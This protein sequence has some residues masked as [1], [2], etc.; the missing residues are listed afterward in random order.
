V[1]DPAESEPIVCAIPTLTS[2]DARVSV[3]RFT[4]GEPRLLLW[5]AHER[6]EIGS[7]CSIAEGAV[8]F[9][10]GEHNTHWATTYPLRI[11]LND[12]LAQLD[13]HPANKG[14]TII[15]HDVWLGFRS[16][17]LSGVKIGDGA[18]VGAGAVVT[19]DV[20]PYAI[21]AGNPARLIKMRFDETTT[22]ALCALQW[23]H[24]PLE[25]IKQHVEQL[26]SGD[27]EPLLRLRDG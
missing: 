8:I 19:Q 5:A 11:A 13:G 24:W 3:G 20:P 17:V 7:F 9:G 22:Q 2:T 14:A 4:Y 25:K 6:I 23:W 26:C 16:M 21:V 10:G 12:P 18:V 27:L 15:G 1:S